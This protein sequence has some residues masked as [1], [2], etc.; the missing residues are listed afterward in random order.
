MGTGCSRGTRSCL[1][2][3]VCY[4]FCG[5]EAREG[6][7][8]CWRHRFPGR[9][10]RAGSGCAQAETGGCPQEDGAKSS[11]GDK[12]EDFV[13]AGSQKGYKIPRPRPWRA[14]TFFKNYLEKPFDT[15]RL[16]QLSVFW[17]DEPDIV[18]SCRYHTVPKMRR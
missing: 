14:N 18:I 1:Q 13:P 8:P 9:G 16:M 17:Y 6:M 12:R 10:Q 3:L 15:V 5:R 4:T 2:G 11:S 7:L